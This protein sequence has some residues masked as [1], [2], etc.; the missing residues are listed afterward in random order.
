[1]AVSI[2]VRCPLVDHHL[3]ELLARIPFEAKIKHGQS[4]Y[5]L[6]KIAE[7]YLPHDVLYRQ[8]MGFSVPVGRWLRS[9]H[10]R[11]FAED[12]L[13]SSAFT[14]RGIFSPSAVKRL[15]NEHLAGQADHTSTLWSVLCL[16]LWCQTFIDHS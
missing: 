1:M 11:E 12:I 10:Y 3:V 14:H 15:W 4:K 7:R 5:L 9:G 6:K 8:K 13:A 16:E 2:E